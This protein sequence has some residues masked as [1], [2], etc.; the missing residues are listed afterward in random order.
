MNVKH[1]AILGAGGIGSNIISAPSFINDVGSK[2]DIYIVDDDL[3]EISNLNR[4]PFNLNDINKQKVKIVYNFLRRVM[5]G[6]YRS[7]SYQAMRVNT[8]QDFSA[9]RTDVVDREDIAVDPF[10]K[11]TNAWYDEKAKE[12]DRR[13]GTIIID[14]RDILEAGVM[15]DDIDI[16]LSY[17]GGNIICL[18]FNPTES[19]SKTLSISDSQ[20]GYEVT[21]SFYIPPALISEIALGVVKAFPSSWIVGKNRKI[22]NTRKV[23]MNIEEMINNSIV[24]IHEKSEEVSDGDSEDRDTE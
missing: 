15:F 22:K 19:V 18:M 10:W 23:V 4:L 20:I 13:R 21:P 12:T 6:S 3:L 11:D 7:I 5:G 9:D 17:N 2:S 8:I 24:S 16:K 1:V 14:C